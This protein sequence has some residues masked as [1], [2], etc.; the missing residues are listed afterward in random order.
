M[1]KIVEE[2]ILRFAQFIGEDNVKDMHAEEKELLLKKMLA[3]QLGDPGVAIYVCAFL[4]PEGV[5]DIENPK[6]SFCYN[7]NAPIKAEFYDYVFKNSKLAS[8]SLPILSK[9]KSFVNLP[10]ND[11]TLAL[12]AFHAL[13]SCNMREQCFSICN[14]NRILAEKLDR[15]MRKYKKHFP[16]GQ[17]LNEDLG[18]LFKTQISFPFMHNGSVYL[19]NTV[20]VHSIIENTNIS[21]IGVNIEIPF[22][23][24]SIQKTLTPEMEA[25]LKKYYTETRLPITFP[26][27]SA[28]KQFINTMITTVSDDILH[29]NQTPQSVASCVKECL[30]SNP[31]ECADLLEYYCTTSIPPISKDVLNND[32]SCKLHYISSKLTSSTNVFFANYL[33]E[34]LDKNIPINSKWFQLINL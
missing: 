12:R 11:E 2:E 10:T 16:L 18:I 3:C 34:Q 22:T 9:F 25:L 4:D 29:R 17:H 14:N 5:G 33:K 21:D 24:S 15:E 19:T 32:E 8:E 30:V 1:N 13:N 28:I 26:Q 31:K 27:E 23:S 6:E 7:K 20:P